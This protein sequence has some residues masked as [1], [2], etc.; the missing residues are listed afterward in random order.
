MVTNDGRSD[1]EVLR[2][3]AAQAQIAPEGRVELALGEKLSRQVRALAIASEAASVESYC[4]QMLE[5][6]VVEYRSGKRRDLDP[7]DYKEIAAWLG[8]S[9]R[10][11]RRRVA[12]GSIPAKLVGRRVRFDKHAVWAALPPA[13]RARVAGCPPMPTARGPVDL[14]ARLTALAKSWGA[15]PDEL[16]AKRAQRM[17]GKETA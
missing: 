1:R 4:E 5:W 10:D 14:A 6:F 3:G 16:A 8:V 9:V 13:G 2:R 15:V 17:N 7:M 11:V 12:D